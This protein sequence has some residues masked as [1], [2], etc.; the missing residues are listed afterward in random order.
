MVLLCA[1]PTRRHE[2][3]GEKTD[4]RESSHG[5]TETQME[6]EDVFSAVTI[7]TAFIS[8]QKKGIDISAPLV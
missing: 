8:E 1:F 4:V 6:R 7:E 2:G 3:R 5:E